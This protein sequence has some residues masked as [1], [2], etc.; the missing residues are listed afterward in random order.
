MAWGEALAEEDDPV[1]TITMKDRAWRRTKP[2][3]GQIKMALRLKVAPIDELMAMRKGAVSD[4]IS[5]A[6]ASRQLDR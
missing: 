2:S 3:E 6:L 1:G 4:A 5:I